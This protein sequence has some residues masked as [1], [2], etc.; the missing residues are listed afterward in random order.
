[1]RMERQ[2]Y[3]VEKIYAFLKGPDYF[4]QSFSKV[5]KSLKTTEKKYYRKKIAIN[6][7]GMAKDL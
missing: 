1:M 4:S 2:E 7:F 6:V 3:D 5:Q